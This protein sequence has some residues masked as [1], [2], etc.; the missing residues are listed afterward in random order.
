MIRKEELMIGN[1][2]RTQGGDVKR[3][4][5]INET[6]VI[7]DDD[8]TGLEYDKIHP[9]HIEVSMLQKSGFSWDGMYA[10]YKKG[11]SQIEYYK[12]EGIIREWYQHKDG[13]RELIAMSRPGF[14][15]VHSFQNWLTINGIEKQLTY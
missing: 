1:L 11:S 8:L 7:L 14:I 9:I 12:H 3:V 10:R 5:E 13:G 4:S 2:V 15:Y 6:Y